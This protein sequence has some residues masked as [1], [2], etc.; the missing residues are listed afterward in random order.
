ME[1]DNQSD[2]EFMSDYL[3]CPYCDDNPLI[4]IEKLENHIKK[5][6]KDEISGLSV[7]KIIF[8]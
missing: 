5:N 7:G 8:N 4:E 1:M 3:Q 6:H 2:S